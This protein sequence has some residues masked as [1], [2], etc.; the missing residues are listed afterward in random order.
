MKKLAIG[1]VIMKVL[2]IGI[3]NYINLYAPDRIILCGDISKG[4][5]KYLPILQEITN[6]GPYKKYKTSIEISELEEP[7]GILGSVSLFNEL[8]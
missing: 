5:K 7:S 6:L 1:I 3:S 8:L 4:L 2:E